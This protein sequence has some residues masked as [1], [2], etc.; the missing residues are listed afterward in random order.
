MKL[1]VVFVFVAAWTT[2]IGLMAAFAY[3]VIADK[4]AWPIALMAAFFTIF[5]PFGVESK[6]KSSEDE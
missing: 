6:P 4:H 2:E 3:A 5:L 1:P